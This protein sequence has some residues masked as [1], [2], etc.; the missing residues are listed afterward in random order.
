MRLHDPKFP[1]SGCVTKSHS[2]INMVRPWALNANKKP[3]YFIH[4]N[5]KRSKEREEQDKT[6]MAIRKE[7]EWTWRK[8]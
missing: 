1:E 7:Q 8:K 4:H 2:G 5:D 6:Y 3:I